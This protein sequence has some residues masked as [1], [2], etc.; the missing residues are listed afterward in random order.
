MN[1]WIIRKIKVV[2]FNNLEIL[3]YLESLE[4]LGILEFIGILESFRG[5]RNDR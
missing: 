5:F 4:N 2:H 1:I 3:D